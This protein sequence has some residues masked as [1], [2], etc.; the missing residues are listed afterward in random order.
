[1]QSLNISYDARYKHLI[2][3]V[4]DTTTTELI[5][6][7]HFSV[8]KQ[9]ELVHSPF[10]PPTVHTWRCDEAVM[11]RL[12]HIAMVFRLAAYQDAGITADAITPEME[13]LNDLEWLFD[14]E[15]KHYS[16]QSQHLEAINAELDFHCMNSFDQTTALQH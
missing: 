11:E 6:L 8:D 15:S 4:V 1:M 9:G 13:Q 7:R 16:L 14:G 5:E 3:T 12:N 2:M 10:L